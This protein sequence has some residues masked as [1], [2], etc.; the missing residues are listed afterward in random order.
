MFLY[1]KIFFITIL[2]F[3]VLNAQNKIYVYPFI[4]LDKNTKTNTTSFLTKKFKKKLQLIKNYQIITN[5]ILDNYYIN[6]H[7]NNKLRKKRTGKNKNASK[8]KDFDFYSKKIPLVL[9]SSIKIFTITNI[10]TDSDNLGKWTLYEA[11]C[12]IDFKLINTVTKK[13]KKLAFLKQS[14]P[15]QQGLTIL[16]NS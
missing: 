9:I 11:K 2:I 15:K 4:S 13:P 6:Q 5:K 7:N 1:K 16:T 3:I 14:Y 12:V 10:E 8:M